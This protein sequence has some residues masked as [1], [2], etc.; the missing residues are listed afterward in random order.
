MH[1]GI[2]LGTIIGRPD[3]L[4]G[5]DHLMERT[6]RVLDRYM[7]IPVPMPARKPDPKPLGR[8]A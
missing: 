5:L 1:D 3:A 8:T 2:K 6:R 7:R 4:K